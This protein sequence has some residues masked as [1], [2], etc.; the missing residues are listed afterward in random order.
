LRQTLGEREVARVISA[1]NIP[2]RHEKPHAAAPP[3]SSG[4]LSQ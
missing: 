3:A 1:R 4:S 2:Q